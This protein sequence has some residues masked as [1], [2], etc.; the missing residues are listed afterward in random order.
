MEGGRGENPDS[1]APPRVKGSIDPL[2]PDHV[3]RL[4]ISKFKAGGAYLLLISYQRCP[5]WPETRRIRN[6]YRRVEIQLCCYI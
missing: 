6:P 5:L 1:Q 2:I 4:T 3:R